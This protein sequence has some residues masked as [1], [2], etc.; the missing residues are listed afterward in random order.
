[1]V[2]RTLPI[3]Q[4]GMEMGFGGIV[5]LFQALKIRLETLKNSYSRILSPNKKLNPA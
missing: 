3:G 5:I 2:L 1:M 4:M